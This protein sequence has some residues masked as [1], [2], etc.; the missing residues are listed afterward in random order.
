MTIGEGKIVGLELKDGRLAWLDLDCEDDWGDVR[1]SHGKGASY[2][3]E[4][5]NDED[6]WKRVVG[7]FEEVGDGKRGDF[8]DGK[9]HPEH[10]RRSLDELVKQV[11]IREI[12]YSCGLSIA[13]HRKIMEEYGFIYDAID[14]PEEWKECAPDYRKEV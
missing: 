4:L 10:V 12:A 5:G 3:V 13:E 7:V 9:Y 14:I 2:V 8:V 1:V 6:G 11:L